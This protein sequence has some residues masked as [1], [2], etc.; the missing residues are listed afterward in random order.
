MVGRVLFSNENVLQDVIVIE[1]M[2]RVARKV[3]KFLQSAA[4]ASEHE[5]GLNYVKIGITIFIFE[6]MEQSGN[7]YSE[8]REG[9]FM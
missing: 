3:A 5:S 6:K 2:Q 9:V 8:K 4:S 1:A 7:N